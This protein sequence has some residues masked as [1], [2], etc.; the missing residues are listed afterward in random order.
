MAERSVLRWKGTSLLHEDGVTRDGRLLFI[1]YRTERGE[2]YA[3]RVFAPRREWWESPT[4]DGRFRPGMASRPLIPL[5]LDLLHDVRA[6]RALVWAEGESD[7]FAAKH[8]FA[9][10]EPTP[11]LAGYDVLAVPGASTWRDEWACF[12]FGYPNVYAIPDADE[13]GRALAARMRRAI[14]H[15]RVVRLREGEDARSTLAR[16][17]EGGLDAFIA[18]ADH[19]AHLEAAFLEADSIEQAEAMLLGEAVRHAA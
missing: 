16:Y 14:P 4:P 3:R 9:G 15:L 11:E 2:L 7:F 1:P 12:A 13:A 5:G 19:M 6:N 8:D 10:I 18:E 17:G